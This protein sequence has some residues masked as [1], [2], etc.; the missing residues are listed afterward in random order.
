MEFSFLQ[1]TFCNYYCLNEEY[2]DQERTQ[3]GN[4]GNHEKNVIH[5]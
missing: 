1:Y 3:N 2:L 4:L 5:Y